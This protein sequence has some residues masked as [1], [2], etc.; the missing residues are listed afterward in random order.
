VGSAVVVCWSFGCE[1]ADL[2]VKGEQQ[3]RSGCGRNYRRTEVSILLVSNK[4]HS[5]RR[6]VLVKEIGRRRVR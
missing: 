5:R 2:R 3:R 4:R 6:D 1:V